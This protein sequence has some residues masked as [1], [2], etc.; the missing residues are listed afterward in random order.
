MQTQQLKITAH[1]YDG[2]VSKFDWVPAIDGILAWADLVNKMGLDEFIFTKTLLDQQVPHEDL[3]IKKEF[4]NGD[5][6]YQC[7]RPIYTATAIVP[8]YIHRRFNAKD[9]EQFSDAKTV[10]TTKTGYKNYRILLRKRITPCVNWYVVGDRDAISDLLKSMTHIGAKSSVGMGRVKQWEVDPDDRAIEFAR[11]CRPLPIEF[12]SQNKI[13][14]VNMTW[15]HRPPYQLLANKRVCVIPEM[16][17]AG[18]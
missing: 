18:P 15:S 13:T 3:P 2:F 7:S 5:W 17:H 14:G 16:P 8:Y 12:A 6:W 1:L 4:F 9:A 11:L 10:E